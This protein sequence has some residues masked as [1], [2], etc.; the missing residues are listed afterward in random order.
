VSTV[1]EI[2]DAVPLVVIVILVPIHH[3]QYPSRSGVGSYRRI[4]ARAMNSN[5]LDAVKAIL[6]IMRSERVV[7]IGVRCFHKSLMELVK[8]NNYSGP[9]SLRNALFGAER[10]FV[11]RLATAD[12]T[13]AFGTSRIRGAK[14]PLQWTH[15]LA[16]RSFNCPELLR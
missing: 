8:V 16:D 13:T 14:Q 9:N 4:G 12:E 5:S 7:E 15:T 10:Q 3:T 6:P 1:I 11:V 2:A